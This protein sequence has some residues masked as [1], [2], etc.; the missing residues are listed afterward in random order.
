MTACVV[1]TNVVLVANLAHADVSPECVIEC[2]KRLND[3][4]ANGT[5]VIDDGYRILAE[6]LKKTT[7]RKAK[8][9]GDLFV[10]WVQR[11][12]SQSERV[13]V[14]PLTELAPQRFVEF[15]D[16]TIEEAFDPNDRKFAAVSH[17]HPEKPP[18]WQAADCK[19]VDWWPALHAC[20]IRVDFLCGEDVC[21]FYARKFPDRLD[22]TLP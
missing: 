11:N 14:V 2:T 17:S 9:V 18:V 8:G 21:R 7:P 6:Y 20:G 4:M 3:L 15:P 10:K 13:H 5:V 16:A 12:L 22:P 1:D 19:W